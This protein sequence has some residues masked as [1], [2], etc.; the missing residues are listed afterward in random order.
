ME[1]SQP[2]T[3]GKRKAIAAL[4]LALVFALG[5]S[6]PAFAAAPFELDGNATS[7]DFPG[8]DWDVV[9]DTGGTSIVS[10]GLIVDF[11]PE[12]PFAQFTGGGSNDE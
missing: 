10:T 1:E 4:S 9:N 3:P 5:M 12:P 6:M 7:S 2:P 11:S 8:D